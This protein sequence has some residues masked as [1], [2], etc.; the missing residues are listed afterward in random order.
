[1]LSRNGYMM[2]N[3]GL[4]EKN[5]EDVSHFIYFQRIQ[6]KFQVVEEISGNRKAEVLQNL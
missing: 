1:M 3:V 5:P 6:Q 4:K 2:Q